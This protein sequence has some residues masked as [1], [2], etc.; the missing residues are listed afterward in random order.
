[1][2]YKDGVFVK[3]KIIKS[4]KLV[5]EYFVEVISAIPQGGMREFR[6]K[7]AQNIKQSG[8]ASSYKGNFV[9]KFAVDQNGELVNF[10]T[11][12]AINEELYLKL[13]EIIK[14]SGKWESGIYNGREVKQYFTLPI[15]LN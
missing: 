5:R 9:F 4:N 12:G 6:L 13:V 3:G 1:V 11:V 2:I 7:L 10:S 14:V 8:L 15:N